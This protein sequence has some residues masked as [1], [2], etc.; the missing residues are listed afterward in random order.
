M[1]IYFI[2]KAAS[3]VAL[4]P[5]GDE[6]EE[7][8]SCAGS[9][10]ITVAETL[11]RGATSLLSV[12]FSPPK[13]LILKSACKPFP[14]PPLIS[15]RPSQ[16]RGAGLPQPGSGRALLQRRRVLF[17]PKV[18]SEEFK[19]RPRF[20]PTEPRDVVGETCR[21]ETPSAQRSP[22]LPLRAARGRGRARGKDLGV[23]RAPRGFFPVRAPGV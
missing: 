23:F 20:L 1:F 11:P 14:H 12:S 19:S 2:P 21:A 3:K 4:T 15:H 10:I 6:G 22:L 9:S 16:L 8:F 17:F 5:C 18:L 7:L 13:L